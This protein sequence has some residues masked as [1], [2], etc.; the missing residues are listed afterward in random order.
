MLLPDP[1]PEPDRNP[2]PDP[3]P[4]PDLDTNLPNF[5]N[6]SE[7]LSSNLSCEPLRQDGSL[8]S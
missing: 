6:W 8:M 3:D 2:S 7:S 1:D 4:D 5:D